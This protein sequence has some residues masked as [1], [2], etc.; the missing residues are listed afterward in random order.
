MNEQTRKFDIYQGHGDHNECVNGYENEA[1]F[2]GEWLPRACQEG[3]VLAATNE[4]VQWYR[5]ADEDVKD[6]LKTLEEGH[7][8]LL[9]DGSGPVRLAVL[10]VGDKEE[11]KFELASFYPECDGV[12]VRIRLTEIHEWAAGLEATLEGEL[13][14]CED[15]QVAFFDTRYVFNKDQYKVGEIYTF[16]LAALANTAEVLPEESREIRIEGERAVEHYRMRGEEISYDESGNVKPIIFRLDE[17]VALFQ[18]D[19][20]YPDDAEFQSPV[21]DD[22]ETFEKFN[23]SFYQFK[24]GIARGC[25]ES[26]EIPLIAKQALFNEVPTVGE[27]VRGHLWLHGHLVLG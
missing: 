6:G 21:I 2:F 3:T 16:N 9:G 4:K 18:L 12:A 14:D 5:E 13:V 20:A 24:I 26:V 17:L 27:P 25:E 10:L 1:E 23:T 7:V 8:V 19:A 15:R 11:K 22:V